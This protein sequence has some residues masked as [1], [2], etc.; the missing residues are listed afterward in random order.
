VK[1]EDTEEQR[2]SDELAARMALIDNAECKVMEQE[3]NTSELFNVANP[4]NHTIGTDQR[5]RSCSII[6]SPFVLVSARVI[7]VNERISFVLFAE[8]FRFQPERPQESLILENA[9]IDL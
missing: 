5:V 6:V 3:S 7:V 8:C 1:L 4:V 2:L 9:A